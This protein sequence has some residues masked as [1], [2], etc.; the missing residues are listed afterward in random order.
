MELIMGAKPEKGS[1][2]GEEN[3]VSVYIMAKSLSQI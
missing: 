1:N 2:S 3:N